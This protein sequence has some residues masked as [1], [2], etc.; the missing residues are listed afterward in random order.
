MHKGQRSRVNAIGSSVLRLVRL[1]RDPSTTAK[2]R[3][4]KAAL[5][6]RRKN[7]PWKG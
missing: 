1:Q 7:P 5:R 3:N 4:I 2:G 6:R